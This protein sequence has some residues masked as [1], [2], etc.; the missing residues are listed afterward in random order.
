MF[1]VNLRFRRCR[2][3]RPARLIN[4]LR[5]ELDSTLEAAAGQSSTTHCLS[6]LMGLP[7]SR[8]RAKSWWKS[9]RR[10]HPILSCAWNS[11]R[12]AIGAGF[13]GDEHATPQVW[14]DFGGRINDVGQI[15]IEVLAQR[16]GYTNKDGSHSDRQVW[17]A[18]QLSTWTAA[19]SSDAVGKQPLRS[20]STRQC[21]AEAE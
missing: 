13:K 1:S 20:C 12:K 7:G 11:T 19:R 2:N 21:Q 17:A 15:R 4:G 14:R 10:R 18:T 9:R 5:V 3:C 8:A 16:S 6:W